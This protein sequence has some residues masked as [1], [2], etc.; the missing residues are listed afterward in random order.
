MAGQFE[1]RHARIEELDEIV[2][3]VDTAFSHGRRQYDFRA[4]VPHV[5]NEDRVSDHWVCLDGGRIVGVVGVYPFTVRM[6]GVEFRAAGIGQVATLPEVR[7]R[8]A[9]SGI[10]KAAAAEMDDGRYEFTWLWGDRQRYGRYGWACGGTS[11][12]VETYDRYLPEAPPA[13]DV[14]ELDPDEH[15][16]RVHDFAMAQPYSVSY[17]RREFRQVLGKPDVALLGFRAA[18]AMLNPN[19]EHPEVMLADGPEDDLLGILAHLAAKAR[20]GGSGWRVGVA[21]GPFDCALARAARRCYWKMEVRTSANFRVCDM[22]AFFRRIA[23]IV[24]PT[25]AGG[26]DEL[27]LCNTDNGQ[28]VRIVCRDG[29][30]TVEPRAGADARRLGTAQISEAAFGLLPLDVTLPGLPPGSPIRRLFGVPAYVSHVY[31]L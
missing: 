26:T 7:G 27:S 19:P 24:E 11:Y 10:L 16:D 1:V 9:M 15:L 23:Q 14:A 20:Q 21:I 30:F 4:E 18:W 8:G 12:H 2:R 5:W 31:S 22:S 3:V 25:L 13:E 29:R 17:S 6:A 28:E